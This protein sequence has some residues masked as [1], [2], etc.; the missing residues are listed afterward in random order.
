MS[1]NIQG[2]AAARNIRQK[3]AAGT[4]AAASSAAGPVLSKDDLQSA[5]KFMNACKV[6]R[7]VGRII[8]R[9]A[10][11]SNIKAVEWMNWYGMM[12]VPTIREMMLEDKPNHRLHER[13]LELIPPR[14][15]FIVTLYCLTRWLGLQA[16]SLY[17]PFD[18]STKIKAFLYKASYKENT[19]NVGCLS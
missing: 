11:L 15:P 19:R 13:H 18:S 16:L 10:T 14:S 7:D 17:I 8:G 4:G 3:V 12:L 2:A 5:Q 1:R 9:L 6:P